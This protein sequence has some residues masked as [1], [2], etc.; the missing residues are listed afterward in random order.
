MN[1][2][3]ILVVGFGNSL[4]GDDGAGPAVIAR[5]RAEPLPAGVRAEDGGSDALRLPAIWK[6]E[7]EVWLVDAVAAGAPPGTV[8]HLDHE[9]VLAVPQRHATAHQLSLPESLRWVAHA[10]PEMAHV[11]YRFWGIEIERVAFAEVLSR[12]V[13]VAVLAVADEL[14]LLLTASAGGVEPRAEG[15]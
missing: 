10:Y 6:G 7:G 12:S 5:L 13:A 9:R 2:N 4:A 8:H 11:R 3:R 14:R 1:R 15:A